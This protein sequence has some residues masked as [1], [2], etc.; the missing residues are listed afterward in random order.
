MV[1]VADFLV[2]PSSAKQVAETEVESV[3]S[4]VH[5]VVYPPS[6]LLSGK[7]Y[8]S[9]IRDSSVLHR[10]EELTGEQYM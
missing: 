5:V 1:T 7:W 6:T 2:T 8:V 10:G 4:E 9:E 3:A